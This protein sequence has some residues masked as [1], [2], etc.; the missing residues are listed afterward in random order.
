MTQV[1]HIF[2][3][4]EAGQAGEVGFANSTGEERFSRRFMVWMAAT[5]VNARKYQIAQGKLDNVKPMEGRSSGGHRLQVYLARGGEPNFR[6]AYAH[7]PMLAYINKGFTWEDVYDIYKLALYSGKAFVAMKTGNVLKIAGTVSAAAQALIRL[8]FQGSMPDAIIYY[9]TPNRNLSSS[10]VYTIVQQVS[11]MAG[12]LKARPDK[13][14]WKNVLKYEGKTLSLASSAANLWTQVHTA[15]RS[16]GNFIA[17]LFQDK[18]F[19]LKV[20]LGGIISA[21]FS[22]VQS[23]RTMNNQ[24]DEQMFQMYGGF[25]EAYANFLTARKYGIAADPI[26]DNDLMEI[27]STAVVSSHLIYLERWKSVGN[28]NQYGADLMTGLFYDLYDSQGD[29]VNGIDGQL[30]VVNSISWQE[31]SKTGLGNIG[32]IAAPDR[33]AHWRSNLVAR[34]PSQSLAIQQLFSWYLIP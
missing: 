24:V 4:T 33:F 31:I 6:R 25:S 34:Q 9:N 28:A 18:W 29:N 12:M 1:D 13:N 7:M 22:L 11:V 10:E 15:R 23:L 14:G 3:R 20:P 16:D 26:I 19:G 2:Y 27:A 17:G 8:V 5:A 32:P 21:S 30:E